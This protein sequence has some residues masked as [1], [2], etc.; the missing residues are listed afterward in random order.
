MTSFS[1][2]FRLSVLAFLL[3]CCAAAEA[4]PEPRAFLKT[5]Y[6]SIAQVSVPAPNV[7]FLLDVGSPMVFSPKGI[8]PL[9]TDHYSHSQRAQLLKECT[10]G[11]GARPCN[12]SSAVGWG[13]Y[14]RDLDNSNNRIGDPDCYYTSDPSK[15]YFLTFKN[16]AYHA[17]LPS[18]VSVGDVITGYPNY[19]GSPY[20]P[21]SLH[22]NYNDLVPNDSRM[23]M[24]KLVLWRLTSAENARLLSRMNVGMSTS[25]QEDSVLAAGHYWADV[26]KRPNWGRRSD[27]PY[28]SAPSWCI[29]FG[30]N[31]TGSGGNYYESQFAISGVNRGLYDATK[32]SPAWAR[33]NRSLLMVP[34]DKFYVERA[35]MPGT[36]DP[37]P[38]LSRFRRYID[39]VESYSGSN[40]TNPELFADGQTPL[41][42]S[43]YARPEHAGK[44]DRDGHHRKKLIQ[45]AN[46]QSSPKV[47]QYGN[48]RI[49]LRE[50]PSSEHTEGLTTGQALGSAIDF[51]APRTAGGTED[52][53]A[54]STGKAGYFP[55]TGSCQSNWVVIFTAGND[56]SNAPRT[57]AAAALELYK[58][59]LR[60]RGR[61]KWNNAW[62]EKEYAMDKG[63]RTLVVGFVDPGATDPNSVKLRKSLNDIAAHGQPKRAGG[64]WVK[65]ETRTALFANDVPGLI[66]ALNEVFS[67][68]DAESRPAPSGAPL[69]QLD[70]AAGATGKLFNASYTSKAFDQWFSRFSCKVL[71]FDTTTNETHLE[72]KWEAGGRMQ[73]VG[74]NRPL[75]ASEGAEGDMS[76]AVSRL[77]SFASSA[78]QSLAQVP[79]RPDDFR[80]WLISFPRP[81]SADPTPLGDM[82]SSNFLTVGPASDE[83][84]FLHT[85]R[86]TLHVLDVETGDEIWG[87]IPP[88]V[89]QG[90]ARVMKYKDGTGMWYDGDGKDSRRSMPVTLLDGL[91]TDGI[92]SE[93]QK[94]VLVGTMG[95][96]GNGLYAMDIST[97]RPSPAF[98][99]AVDNVR[100]D[101]AETP[102]I[103][104]VR[105][106]GLAAE[107]S[108]GKNFDYSDLGLTIQALNFCNISEDFGS[109]RTVGILPGGVGYNLGADSQ[110]KAI[111]VVNPGNGQIYKKLD[112]SALIHHLGKPAPLGMAIAPLT[113]I[114]LKKGNR[115]LTEFF[116]ADSEGN[117]LSC[118]VA[119][120]NV[121]NWELK[122][123]FR[124][125]TVTAN[126]VL[127]GKPVAIPKALLKLR[128]KFSRN[129]VLIGGTCDVL[130][131]GSGTDPTRR[132]HNEQQFIFCL[133]LGRLTGMETTKDLRPLVSE[134]INL[135]WK[136]PGD[137]SPTEKGWALRLKAEDNRNEAE[138]VTTA[139]YFYE[140]K[141]V[142]TTY[143]PQKVS[144]DVCVV[145]ERG[146]GR[147]YILDVDTG[148]ATFKPVLLKNVKLT[149]VTGVRGRLLFSAEEKRSGAL[150][151]AEV[152]FPEVRRLAQNLLEIRLPREGDLPLNPGSPYVDYWRDFDSRMLDE[153]Q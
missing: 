55:V 45:Y 85:N 59:T 133:Q 87:F 17:H 128:R 127:E 6:A 113:L 48:D 70:Q 116:T 13:R 124:L 40:F 144:Q 122:S 62:R 3:F 80:N 36:Y 7:L 39:G 108:S 29:G 114:K 131:P 94:H 60:M 77:K 96:G 26:Y 125:T 58:N 101:T 43:L 44:Y 25:Y 98:L 35:G 103:K 42:T 109:G 136:D 141:L 18:G 64:Q 84:V 30:N 93:D 2:A 76:R 139:P 92:V 102:P 112:D 86:G 74:Q 75:Y 97:I 81:T 147:V 104:G 88:S 28:G 10:Y 66:K 78:F 137:I 110:G 31:G 120:K 50:Y 135:V 138:F 33:I 1:R 83:V 115:I 142:V 68:I 117:V 82:Q 56:E 37:T 119:G 91:L 54:F 118:D 57:A 149:G 105:R 123:L 8:M 67:E 79:S 111:F 148:R 106:W 153:M 24:M 126:G 47:I 95:N 151:E 51:F 73:A 61:E 20:P 4:A 65:D 140:G 129:S 152:E 5:D 53:L 21:Q 46:D 150:K 121:S 107:N 32:D 130:A 90:R 69:I 41:S 63:V 14:G 143:I 22:H 49:I 71:T 134:D 99:W 132:V 34:F 23:Y 9:R 145:S 27:V 11:S 72:E 146:V 19:P 16:A 12:E 89:L 100:Y 38:N 15:P 52:G